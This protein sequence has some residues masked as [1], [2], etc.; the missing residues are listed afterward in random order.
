MTKPIVRMLT[1]V[2]LALGLG[3]VVCS[4]MWVAAAQPEASLPQQFFGSTTVARPTPTTGTSTAVT[5]PTSIRTGPLPTRPKF[6]PSTTSTVAPPT[7]PAPTT[8][9]AA[10]PGAAPP[11][12]TVPLALARQS[13]H[14]SVV[15]P[16]LSGLG[17][18]AL[19]AMMVTQYFLT[20]PGN[21][22]GPT[23]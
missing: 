13:G 17:F 20:G 22:G 3:L 10:I 15:F 9:V 5:T 23:L 19:V 6:V 4:T 1:V 7:T 8:T 16:I 12:V 11:P 2:M 14:V 18:A 21:R